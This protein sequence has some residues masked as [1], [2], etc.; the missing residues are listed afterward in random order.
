MEVLD[1]YTFV[2]RLITLLPFYKRCNIVH[3]EM[4]MTFQLNDIDDDDPLVVFTT[5][6]C[7]L[8]ISVHAKQLTTL[9]YAL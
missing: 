9:H 3:Y 1:W 6:R 5:Q 7:T 2:Y 8:K 4:K